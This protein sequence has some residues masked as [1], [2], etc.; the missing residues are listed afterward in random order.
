MRAGQLNQ[1]IRIQRR[2]GG[3]DAAGQPLDTWED[4]FP[5]DIPAN[6]KGQ[7]GL[8]A[9]TGMQDNVPAS[10]ERYSFRLRFR[11]GITDAMRVVH[12]GVAFDIRQVRMDFERR[13][14]TDLVCE[15]GGNNG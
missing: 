15:Q 7:S 12:R 5:F 8:G 13:K 3:T 11:E 4:V 10:I 2:T 6:I 9:I 1:R 14:W